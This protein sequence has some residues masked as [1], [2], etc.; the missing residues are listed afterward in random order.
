MVQN[1]DWPRWEKKPARL[2]DLP[3]RLAHIKAIKQFFLKKPSSP[4]TKLV[5]VLT[6]ST[7]KNL[8]WLLHFRT[9]ISLL[10]KTSYA[11]I[12]SYGQKRIIIKAWATEL[13]F[14]FKFCP[15]LLNGWLWTRYFTFVSIIFFLCRVEPTPTLHG[16]CE[17]RR[18]QRK[19]KYTASS[20][21][22]VNTQDFTLIH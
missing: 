5:M 11:K 10:R 13:D 8:V 6:V 14:W 20:R 7:I 4:L 15:F 19:G 22:G 17:Q 1:F 21:H 18:E 3:S 16:S 2:R 12:E 9:L